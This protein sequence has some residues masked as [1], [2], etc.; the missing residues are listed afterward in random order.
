MGGAS[1][2]EVDAAMPPESATPPTGQSEAG[3][4]VLLDDLPTSQYPNLAALTG[5]MLQASMDDRFRFGMKVLL[6]GLERQLWSDLPPPCGE[7]WGG[8]N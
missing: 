1:R 4:E 8:G 7:G 3:G 2:I 5:V 6:D